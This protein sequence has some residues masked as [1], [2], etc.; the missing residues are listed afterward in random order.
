MW[1]T[2]KDGLTTWIEMHAEAADVFIFYGHTV[3][4]YANAL[5]CMH[6]S[7]SWSKTGAYGAISPS[8][9]AIGLVMG[10]ERGK[11]LFTYYSLPV[12]LHSPLVVNLH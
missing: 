6:L 11:G 12:V 8:L 4:I 1:A 10:E 2:K 3:I 7:I 5:M 9:K